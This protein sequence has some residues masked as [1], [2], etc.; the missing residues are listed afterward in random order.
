[1][2]LKRL[3][4]SVGTLLFFLCISFAYSHT[5]IAADTVKEGQEHANAIARFA[6][7][8][9]YNLDEDQLRAVLDP[10]LEVDK[11]IKGLRVIESIENEVILQFY[12]DKNNKVL[13]GETL[14]TGV[15]ELERYEAPSTFE[16][17][18]IG[19]VIVYY[20]PPNTL[21]LTPEELQ[22]LSENKNIVFGVD[23]TWKPWIIKNQD[24]SYSGFDGDIIKLVNDMLG[25]NMTFEVGRWS[26]M[27]QKFK[28]RE[29][30]GLSSSAV[31]AERKSF[32]DFSTP[33][34]SHHKMLFVKTGD[35]RRISTPKDLAG[36]KIAF[37]KGNLFIQKLLGTYPEAIPVE[38][39]D[40]SEM[41]DA[42]LSNEID[43]FVGSEVTHY[44]I[45]E[46]GVG[47]ITP[48]FTLGE[49]LEMVFST[50]NDMPEFVSILNKALASIPIGKRLEI[51]SKYAISSASD[52]AQNLAL[53]QEE[54]Q[55][56]KANPTI[57][58]GVEEWYPFIRT[59]ENGLPG[60]IAGDFIN[61]VLEKTGLKIK[62]ISDQWSTLLSNFEKGQIDLLPATYYTDERATYG[63]YSNPYFSGKEFL[64]I[65]D[66]NTEIKSFED[67][68]G[69]KLAIPE[70][71]GTIPKVKAKFPEIEIV[72]TK[73]Q[74][75]SLYA[76]LNGVAD[77]TF[78]SQIVMEDL[79]RKELMTGIRA[80]IQTEFEASKL[81][82]FSHKEKPILQS[83]LKKA[84]DSISEEERRSIINKWVSSNNIQDSAGQNESNSANEKALLS[85][86]VIAAMGIGLL[87]IFAVI[88]FILSK[89][90][91]DRD[92]STFFG[93]ASF[94]VS[95][96][97]ALSVLVVGVALMNWVAIKDSHKRTLATLEQELQLVLSSSIE[98]LNSWVDEHKNF[99]T[100]L[101]RDPV[102]V[103]ITKELLNVT[104]SKEALAP[105]EALENARQYFAANKQF[106]AAG[107][108]IISPD[109]VSIGSRRDTN[110]G[111]RNFIAD[112]RPDLIERAF[113]G[114]AV[115]IPPI[116]SDVQ[117]TKDE[118]QKPLTMFFAAP[119]TDKD[120]EVL[121]VMTERIRPSGPLSRILHHGRIGLS[122]ETYAFNFE[123]RMVSE[124]RF[125]NQLIETGLLPEKGYENVEIILK[126]PKGHNLNKRQFDKGQDKFTKIVNK[127]LEKRENNQSD[128]IVN[129]KEGY[130][131]YRGI[132]VVGVGRWLKELDLGLVTEM[133]FD[134]AMTSHHTFRFN[135]LVISIIATTMAVGATLFTLIVGQRSYRSLSKAR[136]ELEDRV[137]E[138]TKELEYSEKRTRSIIDNAADG[139]IVINPQGTVQSFSPAAEDIFGYG[140]DEVV[141]QNIKMLMPEPYQSEHD[142]YLSNYFRDGVKKVIGQNREVR[143]RRKDGSEFPMDLAVGKTVI[144]EEVIFTGIIRDIS[145]RVEAERL[146][147]ENEATLTAILDSMPAIVFLKKL[148]GTFLKV[149]KGYQEAYGVDREWVVGKKLYDFLDHDLADSLTSFDQ[150]VLSKGGRSEQEHTVVNE[151][152]ET[153]YHGIMFPVLDE[154]G[155]ITSYGG[156]EIDIT[157]R[158]QAEKELQDAY[159]IISSSIEYASRIQ[160]S[161]LP[162]HR[163]LSSLVSDYFIWWEP[164]DV[165]GGDLYWLGAWGDGCLIILGDCTGH[166]VPGAFMT[167]ISIAAIERAVSEVEGGDLDKLISRTHQYIQ[168]M[169]GQHYDG[170]QSDDGIELGACYFIPEEPQ[171]KFVGAR[172]NLLIV[173]D[174]NNTV[175][176]GTKAG[177]G[178][179]N[180]P[181][182]QEYQEEI[183]E[184]KE[185]QQFYM[186]SDGLIDQVGG[187]RRRMMGKK[188]L[189]KVLHENK[190]LAM[191][192]QKQSL[193]DTLKTY[194]G[195][196]KRRDDISMIG[197]K[198]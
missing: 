20:E 170:G 176:K 181:Y 106:G 194:Q 71:F 133:D 37:H 92:L 15:T 144:G 83:I 34:T 91:S 88:V 81:Y 152:G 143:G 67:L 109:K 90:K 125:Q 118:K 196:E 17:E 171:M 79:I 24:G 187:H 68:R 95:I 128:L 23:E 108:F 45:V 185:N 107:F 56:L 195:D 116:R 87:I 115:F 134:E 44:A 148:N 184:L 75:D 32:A 112:V 100:Q 126:A 65:R 123:G 149:N 77:A 147:K 69:K 33:Y 31:H 64:Y 10:Y 80:I 52:T 103:Q 102:L 76:V 40:N 9:I 94:R 21:G 48:A 62:V 131:D 151:D 50:R 96:L 105:S 193:Q 178:Y 47:F 145:A 51:K 12:R 58:V 63:L 157:A 5:L 13:Y 66:D 114:E 97:I 43:G 85:A 7:K 146:Q 59:E 167:L 113:K 26:D 60:G 61:L 111:T 141:G 191:E 136:D 182:I 159:N 163:L 160:E 161:A 179:R 30:D 3:K 192:E 18:N 124:S 162:D 154:L 158:K 29:I 186:T 14:P 16:Q 153:T 41:F 189:F 173:E 190:H 180:V 130:P 6:A 168:T 27:V 8:A 25:T 46:K 28:N 198:F 39:S 54:K 22:W 121:A 155:N 1:M 35:K 99:I 188:H 73:S 55:W 169:L 101:G 11:N 120:G 4:I 74:L 150:D 135:L 174:E 93:A 139:I 70:D 57:S 42:L 78:E 98:R 175:I 2:S 138:R 119:I 183:I 127:S 166:G 172:F 140:A 122:G 165:V 137:V 104:P 129:V 36:K 72:E 89:L 177:M 86:P 19:K 132:S 38:M 142:G 156:V 117:L 49:P 82:F 84:L 197:F 53:N 164:R 110:I